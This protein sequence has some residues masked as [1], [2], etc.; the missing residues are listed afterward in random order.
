MAESAVVGYPHDIK[1]EGIY[2]Y[3]TLK[4]DCNVDDNI[5][6]DLK[7]IV[8]QKIAGYAIPDLI[9]VTNIQ[10]VDLINYLYA[11]LGV[12]LGIFEWFFRTLFKVPSSLLLGLKCFSSPMK[13]LK[14][15]NLNE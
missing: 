10:I 3:I 8:R 15:N 4:H 14:L 1:G 13:A 7:M 2:A 9:Q 11:R 12:H 5:I 6:A